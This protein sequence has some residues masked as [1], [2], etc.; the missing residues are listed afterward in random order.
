MKLTVP[1]LLLALTMSSCATI[2]KA[3]KQVHS[4]IAYLCPDGAQ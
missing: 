4:G 2:Y 1:L 3:G